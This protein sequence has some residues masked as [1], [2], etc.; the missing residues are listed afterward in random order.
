MN[1][2]ELMKNMKN[3]ESQMKNMKQE[4]AAMR[5]TGSA[6]GNMVS[7]TLNGA[8]ELL[9]IKIDPIAVDPR[10]V[11][12]LQDIIVAAHHAAMEKVQEEMKSKYGA[13]LGGSGMDLSS[14]GM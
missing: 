1:P 4:M 8:F 5:V 10:D 11:G 13:M 6:G 9:E 7:V 14:L 2:F 12:M 3:I